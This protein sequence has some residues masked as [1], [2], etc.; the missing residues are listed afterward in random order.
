[1]QIPNEYVLQAR[2]LRAD[3]L[4]APAVW[5]PRR[6]A[7]LEWL[8][9]FLVRSSAAKYEL[10]ETEASDLVALERFLR[11]QKVPVAL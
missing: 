1:M 4:G 2:G 7:L 9:A 5:L 6:D 10:G 3:I 11:K 8:N